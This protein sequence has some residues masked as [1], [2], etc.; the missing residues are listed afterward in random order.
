MPDP[1]KIPRKDVQ[2]EAPEEFTGFQGEELF[3]IAVCS[4]LVT[5]GHIPVTKGDKSPV[6]DR[7]P[8]GVLS[9]II[10][11]LLRAGHGRLA[12]NGP[13]FPSGLLQET[14]RVVRAF[15][16]KCVFEPLKELSAKY[17]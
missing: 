1:D 15:C 8:M 11:N 4:V 16:G 14:T 13:L 3:P 10:E 17:G 9:Q 7:D 6:R 5:E 2:E 12:E